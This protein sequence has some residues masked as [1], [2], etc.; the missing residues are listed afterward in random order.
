VYLTIYYRVSGRVIKIMVR[1][2][3]VMICLSLK[4]LQNIISVVTFNLPFVRYL[5]APVIFNEGF[6]KL[7]I[8]RYFTLTGSLSFEDFQLFYHQGNPRI[9]RKLNHLIVAL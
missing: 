6:V 1:C 9:T 4:R 7:R 3:G 2:Y 8:I 5:Y